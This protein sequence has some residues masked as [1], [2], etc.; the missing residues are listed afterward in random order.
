LEILNFSIFPGRFGN[1][2]G[3]VYPDTFILYFIYSI[4]SLFICYPLT[5][6]FP[7]FRSIASSQ[8]LSTGKVCISTFDRFYWIA[9]LV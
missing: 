3:T 8:N 4:L 6:G 2:F 1:F 5:V 7:Y 9:L